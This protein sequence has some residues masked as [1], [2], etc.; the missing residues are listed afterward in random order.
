MGP[1]QVQHLPRPRFLRSEMR[2]IT[3]SAIPQHKSFNFE[4]IRLEAH[5]IF[6]LIPS[7][8]TTAPHLI[9]RI[10][11]LRFRRRRSH[12]PPTSPTAS[13]SSAAA[14]STSKYAAAQQ[15]ALH[16]PR[17]LQDGDEHEHV[18][19]LF[20]PNAGGLSVRFLGT[21]QARWENKQIIY[22]G[23]SREVFRTFVLMLKK[24]LACTSIQRAFLHPTHSRARYCHHV[25]QKHIVL[26][27]C[28]QPCHVHT[29][30]PTPPIGATASTK[31]PSR[32][33]STT[34]T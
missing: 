17:P 23:S 25:C 15:L 12:S 18:H 19:A 4:N 3:A 24:K 13:S 11:R 28:P 8:C 32:R 30:L 20:A 21:P 9:Y 16:N 31:T 1:T 27:S 26:E 29:F 2:S 6:H 10:F 34:T 14:S 33:S 22:F 7:S 5:Y